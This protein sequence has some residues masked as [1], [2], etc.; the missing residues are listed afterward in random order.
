MERMEREK[1]DKHV[2]KRVGKVGRKKKKNEK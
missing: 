1:L 2:E